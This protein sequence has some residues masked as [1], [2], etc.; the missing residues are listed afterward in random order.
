MLPG[1]A[2]LRPGSCRLRPWPAPRPDH[3]TGEETMRLPYDALDDV[4]PTGT[5]R[6]PSR[7]CRT[8]STRAAPVALALDSVRPTLRHVRRLLVAL[9]AVPVR[10]R[11]RP[12]V[13]RRPHA[14]A[15]LLRGRPR[16]RPAPPP[17]CARSHDG[18][19]DLGLVPFEEPF[20]RI[21]LGG[22]PVNEG[23]KTSKSRASIVGCT[24]APPLKCRSTP[25]E[26]SARSG[27]R[28]PRRATPSGPA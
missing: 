20:P 22:L 18:L 27:H 3:R 19:S 9:P 2:R 6:S 5:R 15:G 13:G 25:K 14:T 4:R 1:C 11:L 17:L 21:R 26:P 24:A 8:L 28:F 23:A 10:R 12:A 16:A 7:R